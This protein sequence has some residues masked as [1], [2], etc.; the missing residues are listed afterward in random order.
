MRLRRAGRE[1][2]QGKAQVGRDGQLEQVAAQ[3]AGGEEHHFQILDVAGRGIDS[4][5]KSPSGLSFR[6]AAGD[7]ESR[8]A[9]KILRARFLAPLGMTAWKCFSAACSVAP[10]HRRR[11]PGI[12]APRKA[13]TFRYAGCHPHGPT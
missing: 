3:E 8:I 5:R 6:G 12:P 10:P 13:D 1:R 9:P 4:L 11:F 7:E 2:L